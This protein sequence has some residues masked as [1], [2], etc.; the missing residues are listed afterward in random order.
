MNNTS[1]KTI[2]KRIRNLI[3]WVRQYEGD[4]D[5]KAF[6]D[7]CYAIQHSVSRIVK[8]RAPLGLPLGFPRLD[9]ALVLMQEHGDIAADLNALAWDYPR[10]PGA[11]HNTCDCY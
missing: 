2:I 10:L 7:E 6:Q 11:C 4:V 9:Y 8:M 5:K 1:R 3:Q